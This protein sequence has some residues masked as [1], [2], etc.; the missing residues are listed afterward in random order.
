M[1]RV[2]FSTAVAALLW[3]M[4]VNAADLSVVDSQVLKVGP[5]AHQLRFGV[6]YNGDAGALNYRIGIYSVNRKVR[7][8]SVEVHGHK[9]GTTQTVVV[10]PDAVAC[11]SN[12]E[13][14]VDDRDQI[15]EPDRQNNVARET[16]QPPSKTGFCIAQL[17][18]C[19]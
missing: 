14:R 18:K 17:D 3:T 16:W 9:P 12:I 19:P 6:R 15:A 2:L 10:P 1:L 11:D 7:L 13:I 4:P 5:C 8:H